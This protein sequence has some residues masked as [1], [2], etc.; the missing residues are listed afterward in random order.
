MLHE[1]EN[2]MVISLLRSFYTISQ[3]DNNRLPPLVYIN[4]YHVRSRLNLVIGRFNIIPWHLT[5]SWVEKR[6]TLLNSS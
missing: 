4:L 5:R 6:G 1:T 2:F 3:H